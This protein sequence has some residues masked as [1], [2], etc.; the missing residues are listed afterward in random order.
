MYERELGALGFSS[1]ESR[2]YLKLL[3]LGTATPAQISA[4]TDLHRAYAYDVLSKL[5]D[6]G[7]AT[8]FI[9]FGRRVYRPVEPAR[10]ADLFEERL[11]SFKR[12]LPALV[13]GL[14]KDPGDVNVEFYRSQN[15]LKL[16]LKDVMAQTKCGSEV[17]ALTMGDEEFSALEPLLLSQYFRFLSNNRVVERIV[18]PAGGKALVKARLT[19]YRSLDKKYLGGVATWIYADRVF[20]ILVGDPHVGILIT[21]PTVSEAYRRQFEL[22]WR[23]AKPVRRTLV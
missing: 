13:S 9:A 23:S 22:F 16:A 14:A 7:L 12:V 6:K 2:V 11:D 18:I 3:E 1:N 20:L 5:A 10:I 8:S 4:K 15:L 17:L 19:N 21:S